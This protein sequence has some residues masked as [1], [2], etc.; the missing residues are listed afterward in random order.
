ILRFDG[1]I[2]FDFYLGLWGVR[3]RQSDPGPSRVKYGPS[4][5]VRRR[6]VKHRG[7]IGSDLL[8]HRNHAPMPSVGMRRTTRVF[9]ARVLRSGRRL[10]SGPGEIKHIRATAAAG[11]VNGEEWIELLDNSGDGGGGGGDDDEIQ[12]KEN[13][14]RHNAGSKP[15]VTVM[16]IEEKKAENKLLGNV[17]RSSVNQN[18]SADTMWG[19]VYQRKRKKI[20][21]ESSNFYGSSK[22]KMAFED[23]K[24]GKQFVRKQWR[25]NKIR[26]SFT[27][28]LAESCGW[29]GSVRSRGLLAVVESS[30]HSTSTCWFACLLGLVLRYMRR[31]DLGLLQLSA[32]LLSEPLAHVF[33]SHGIHFSRDSRSIKIPF[34][35]MY[36]HL[37]LLLRA[38]R[39]PYILVTHSNFMG[40]IVT[41]VV[42]HLPFVSSEIDSPIIETV[43]SGNDNS[44][45]RK[46]L[47]SAV[48]APRLTGRAVQFRSGISSRNIRKR[49]SSLRSR[50]R[51]NPSVFHGRKANGA[52]VSNLPSYRHDGIS[53]SPVMSGRQLR[54][55]VRKSSTP[56]KELK[57]SLVELTQDIGSTCCSSNILVI[58]PDKCYRIKDAIVK[59][60]K[61][62]AT[63]LW[64][65]AV[66]KD[67]ITR[68]SL[69]AQ[70]VMRPCS[71]NRVTHDIIWTEDI[72]NWKLEFP[73]R[74][75]WLIFKEL[76]K[77]CSR[78]NVQSPNASII[79]VPGV[80]EV[81]GYADSN[82]IP[83]IRPNSYISMKDDELSRA[84]EKR[85]S[86]YDMD[87]E[88][89]EWLGKF[90]NESSAGNE[91]WG[92]VSEEI[93]ELVI[94]AFEKAFYCSPDDYSDE[95]AAVNLCLNLE[96]KEV[97]EAVYSYWK[98][99]RKNKHS[100]LVRVFQFY[101][102][103]RA[104]LLPKPILRKKRSLKRQASH[105]GRGK[106][107][108]FLRAMAEE[109][110]AAEDQNAL[111][112]VQEAKAAASRS[113]DLAV[114]KRQTAQLL[115]ESADL[116][117][118]KA[119]MALRIAEA[120]RVAESA[121]S[122]TTF[123]LC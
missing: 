57:S 112:R 55:S 34:C 10:W 8:P 24:Y 91:Q 99:K 95:K 93:F 73:N 3:I 117:T 44:W 64:S 11:A 122:A 47:R 104:Q 109:Q 30:S 111:H 40:N 79:P 87:S 123:F 72:N 88:D 103:I 12:S 48:G 50:R 83:F 69:T 15:E 80:Y 2:F 78:R 119:A 94:D 76:Y 16:D 32:F 22:K 121:D 113:E 21:T 7:R 100:A 54:S 120:A 89:D 90:N 67:G 17:L 105:C 9:G 58:E 66:K 42:E 116:V 28:E 18:G 37:D 96:R 101:Q 82:H 59:L 53:L 20:E 86:N 35:F 102:P 85:T 84:L 65:L 77:E 41:E 98:K 4:Q 51:K 46:V 33:S 74:R 56:I 23:R 97:V 92:H 6:A 19:S 114:V 108:T 26:E 49:R 68:Y 52:L 13:G 70:K 31:A 1:V 81:A 14:W 25:K 36:L 39:L 110:D 27:L 61:P 62:S 106:Q 43:T 75:D 5:L 29:K 118:Y 38:A 71:S 107:R 63:K 115:M 60:E 45:K